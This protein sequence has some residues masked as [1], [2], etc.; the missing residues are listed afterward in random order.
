ML[1]EIIQVLM[2]DPAAAHRLQNGQFELAGVS[3]VEHRALLAALG[4]RNG[5]GKEPQL[6]AWDTV[7]AQA[8][9]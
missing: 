4:D 2:K 3:E 6:G 7:K 1:K 9:F 5:F 8:A